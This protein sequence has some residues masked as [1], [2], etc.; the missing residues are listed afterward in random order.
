MKKKTSPIW[1]SSITEFT[2]VVAN[3]RTYADVLRYYKLSTRGNNYKTLKDR[4]AYEGL[5]TTH[6]N[7][8]QAKVKYLHQK[9]P[10]EEVLVENST[11]SRTM[12]KKR[13]VE[14]NLLEY[15][16]ACCGNN[17]EWN[18]RKLTLQL[19]HKN[20]IPNDNR[21]HN[22]CFLCPNCHSQTDTYA[23]KNLKKK[24][25]CKECQKPIKGTGKT[26][27][28]TSCI[29]IAT[30]KA[31]RPSYED[32]VVQVAELGYSATGRLYGVSDNAVRKW[33]DNGS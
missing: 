18:G 30:R 9:T 21:L 14:E 3:S 7:P 24:H 33:L 16:C 13:L 17:G 1:T 15:V 10:L 29:G 32:L 2:S 20:G 25:F 31:S 11:Y 6:F 4:I 22:L 28:C 12:L 23:G 8:L 19:E 5:L 27:L 26:G